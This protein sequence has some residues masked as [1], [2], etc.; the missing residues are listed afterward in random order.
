MPLS[1]TFWG[2]ETSVCFAF[3]CVESAAHSHE[4][5][6]GNNENH[7]TGGCSGRTPGS[8]CGDK[9]INVRHRFSRRRF[10]DIVVVDR[11]VRSL[12]AACFSCLRIDFPPRSGP[13]RGSRRRDVL[14]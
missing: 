9:T 3:N 6:Q 11:S 13:P 1:G 7:E 2:V 5:D 14:G 8:L 4:I 10:F 12:G